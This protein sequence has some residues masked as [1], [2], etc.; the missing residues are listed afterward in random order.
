[1][2]WRRRVVLVAAVAIPLASCVKPAAPEPAVI[3]DTEPPWPAPRDAIS[4]IDNAG[5]ARLP[6]DAS[7][8]LHVLTLE[9]FVLR[10]Q[11]EVPAYLGID[12]LRAVQAPCHTHDAAGTVWLEGPGGSE[13]TLGQLFDVWGVRLT[14]TCLGAT[15]GSVVV[16]VDGMVAG[17]PRD[18]RLG[19][20]TVIRVDALPV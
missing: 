4:Y 6:L 13:V 17:S 20:T 19:D 2:E 3:R 9:V 8:T 12:R 11:V 5:L 15:C 1:M 18:V 14:S 10:H 7:D 16:T